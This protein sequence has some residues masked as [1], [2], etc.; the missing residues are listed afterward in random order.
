MCRQWKDILHSWIVKI[1]AIKMAKLPKMICRFTRLPIKTA[2]AIFI[3]LRGKIPKIYMA[4]KEN[5]NSQRNP[6]QKE[7]SGKHYNLIF[8]VTPSICSN[9]N[10]MVET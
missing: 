1:N 9:K 4:P 6:E 8:Q 2:A 5:Q 3:K 10:R 7:Q